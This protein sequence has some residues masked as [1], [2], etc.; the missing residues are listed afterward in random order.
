MTTPQERARRSSA[1]MAGDPYTLVVALDAQGKAE[2]ELYLDDGLSNDF[3][4]KGAYR[5]VGYEFANGELRSY[6]VEGGAYETAAL[7]E[8]VVVLGLPKGAAPPRA[9]VGGAAANGTEVGVSFGPLALGGRETAGPASV[10]VRR[11]M[12]PVQGDWTLTFQQ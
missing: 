1:A 3:R 2:G 10:V 8:R 11:P 5:V 12:V 4:N 6:T 9:T 7:V